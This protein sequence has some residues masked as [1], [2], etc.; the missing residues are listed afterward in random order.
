MKKSKMYLIL[1][2]VL[3][4]SV[5][6]INAQ[7]KSIEKMPEPIGGIRGIAENLKYPDAA[8]KENIQGKV[9]IK[10]LV[11]ETGKVIKTEVVKSLHPSCD[12]AARTAIQKTKFTPG[13]N[14]GKKVKAE[15]VIPVMFKLNDKKEK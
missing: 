1:I 13:E 6:S 14:K 11:D 10:A 5:L 2:S 4:I 8:K 12:K 15:V 9:V 7:Q 3:M